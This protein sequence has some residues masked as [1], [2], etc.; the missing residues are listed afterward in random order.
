MRTVRSIT[1]ALALV[2]ATVAGCSEDE[3]A[4]ADDAP[5][6][7]PTWE[8]SVGDLGPTRQASVVGDTVIVKGER[9]LVGLDRA[10]GKLR[11]K[12]PIEAG[13]EVR[14]TP[15]SVV[16]YDN[17]YFTVYDV[18][19]GRRG[20]VHRG[21]GPGNVVVSPSAAFV[22]GCV[23]KTCS[24]IAY[25]LPTGAVRWRYGYRRAD[26][27]AAGNPLVSIPGDS[28]IRRAESKQRVEP[29]IALPADEVEI[30]NEGESVS[31]LTAETGK[32]LGSTEM[33]TIW[34]RVVDGSTGLYWKDSADCDVALIGYSITTGEHAWA[35]S[36]GR[37]GV[38]D[39]GRELS[40]DNAAWTPA[41][42]GH[43]AAVTTPDRQPQ[44]IELRSG[45]VSWTGEAGVHVIDLNET[46]VLARQGDGIGP[47]V[48][49]DTVNGRQL[50]KIELPDEHGPA[51][52]GRP[53]L[54]RERLTFS[55]TDTSG[56]SPREVLQVRNAQ[57]GAI[58]WAAPGTNWTLGVGQDWIVTAADGA[59]DENSPKV[60]R[61]FDG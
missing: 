45:S 20:F 15:T 31:V 55:L 18:R 4:G 11:W 43:I 46:T 32:L 41:I 36:V 19:T 42:N 6:R 25:Q 59:E 10:D 12:H 17:A 53:A 1:I 35:R 22:H 54:T 26:G 13:S 21:E 34:H 49:L 27:D 30:A 5:Q 58:Q 61:L 3:S 24:V 16:V 33:R 29:L 60:I 7:E 23:K 47:L 14:A 52:V 38:A 37:W 56:D 50:W 2:A 57:T 44:L 48:G 39:T 9:L 51:S 8:S 28:G 40:C